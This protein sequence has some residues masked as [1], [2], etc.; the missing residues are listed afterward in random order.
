MNQWINKDII[1]KFN[2]ETAEIEHVSSVLL[3]KKD[4]VHSYEEK[5]ERKKYV[6]P[7]IK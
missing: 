5:N 4:D 1:K 6:L 7:M 3:I 2:E